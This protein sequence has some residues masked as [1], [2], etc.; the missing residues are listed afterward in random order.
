MKRFLFFISSISSNVI[1]SIRSVDEKYWC[2]IFALLYLLKYFLPWGSLWGHWSREALP[3]VLSGRTRYLDGHGEFSFF[4][5][6]WNQYNNSNLSRT[7]LLISC[8]W[9]QG[10]N[11]FQLC[12]FILFS[13]WKSIFEFFPS[14]FLSFLKSNNNLISEYNFMTFKVLTWEMENDS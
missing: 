9:R 2:L 1:W 10:C 14:L 5:F 13:L 12:K 8:L 11:P 4:F 7:S 6:F 3:C